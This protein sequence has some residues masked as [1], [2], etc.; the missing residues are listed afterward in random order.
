M[1]Q[2]KIK[3][4]KWE[5]CITQTEIQDVSNGQKTTSIDTIEIGMVVN[6]LYKNIKV[7]T[8][9]ENILEN[10]AIEGRVSRI[11]SVNGET[12]GDLSLGDKVYIPFKYICGI[13]KD[14]NP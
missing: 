10:K 1:T 4:P 14:T 5:E 3:S 11:Y 2:N 9:I 6:S 12:V 13:N 8:E 7:F